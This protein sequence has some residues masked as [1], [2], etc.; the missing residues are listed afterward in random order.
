MSQTVTI[1]LTVAGTDSGPFDLYSD[2]D[3]YAFPFDTGISKSALLAGYTSTL[4]PDSATIIRV[5]STGVCTNYK[6]LAITGTTT[7]TTSSSTTSSSTTQSGYLIVYARDIGVGGN[8]TPVLEYTVNGGPVVTLGNITSASCQPLSSL[9]GGLF[10]G[11]NVVFT[12]PQT[13]AMGGTN[14][15]NA[16][17]AISSGSAYLYVVPVTGANNVS[18]TVDRDN[19]V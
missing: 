9:I 15:A 19:I 13:Y 11:D 18:I 2:A 14:G 6:D 17:P 10:A 1:T 12:T 5:K 3:G 4:V 8:S 16:C 7:T